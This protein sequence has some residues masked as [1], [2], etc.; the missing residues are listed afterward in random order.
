MLASFEEVDDDEED[1][2]DAID[3]AAPALVLPPQQLQELAVPRAEA[4]PPPEG[5]PQGAQEEV[6]ERMVLTSRDEIEDLEVPLAELLGGA[7]TAGPPSRDVQP[8]RT[9]QQAIPNDAV[10]MQ[11]MV[12]EVVEDVVLTSADSVEDLLLPMDQALGIDRVVDRPAVDEVVAEVME[13]VDE[14]VEEVTLTD[15]DVVE[16]MVMDLEEVLKKLTGTWLVD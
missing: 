4:P 12:E 6:V 11:N 1:E 16:E 8:P 14:V 2:G 5:P 9:V 3:D 13:V 7:A 15:E 10:I